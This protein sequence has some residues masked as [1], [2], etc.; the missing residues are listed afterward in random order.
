MATRL[1]IGAALICALCLAAGSPAAANGVVGE[2][3]GT[4]DQA[5]LEPIE[6]IF[7]FDA[8]NRGSSSYPEYSCGG[9]LSGGGSGGS[10]RF[11][12]VITYGRY[13]A[14]AN[15]G[16]LDGT[17]ELTIDGDSM[18]VD[19]NGDFEGN[20]AHASGVL[21]RASSGPLGAS[22]E[23]CGLTLVGDIAAGLT[24]TRSLRSY[25]EQSLAKFLNCVNKRPDQ[26]VGECARHVINDPLWACSQVPGPS[27]RE[28]VEQTMAAAEGRC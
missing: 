22:C 25:I 14:E 19:W 8:D 10:Y 12:E 24:R 9:T 20:P 16:C 21:Y 1:G 26:C 11:S 17:I 23:A 4:L 7:V 5:G 6:T 15:T 28:C 18:S 2:W 13:D 27:Y 3:R